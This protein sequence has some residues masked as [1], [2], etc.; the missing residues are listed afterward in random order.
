MHSYALHAS[1]HATTP[2]HL[3]LI[4]LIAA[5]YCVCEMVHSTEASAPLV[6][7]IGSLI[8]SYN[9]MNKYH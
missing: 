3:F 8:V 5:F 6:L 7:Y 4:S 1:I 2:R 9:Y